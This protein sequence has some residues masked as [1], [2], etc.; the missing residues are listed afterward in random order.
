[1]KPGSIGELTM[2]LG[3]TLK[4]VQLENGKVEW[5]NSPVIYVWSTCENV[6]WYLTDLGNKKWKLPGNFANPFAVAADYEPELYESELL[7]PDL[8]SWYYASL[9]GM[10]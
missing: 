10:L 7:G 9:I 5:A 1:M 2:F 4:Q 8:A 6:E 3:A